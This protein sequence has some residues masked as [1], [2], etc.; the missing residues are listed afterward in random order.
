MLLTVS[1][2]SG[3]AD[4]RR[5][6]VTLS[7][8]IGAS[9]HQADRIGIIATELASN[10]RKHAGHGTLIAQTFDDR[11]GYGFELLAFDEGPGMG[12]VS[13]CL[14]DGYSSTAS[15]GI[16][17]GAVKRFAD[18]FGIC[19]WPE[20]GTAIVARVRL[21]DVADEPSFLVGSMVANYPGEEV[22]GDAFAV[23]QSA[24]SCVGLLAD[25]SGH[26]ELAQEAA[27]RAVQIFS[28]KH[29]ASPDAICTD[30]H[31]NLR[32][33]RG[34]AI[35]VAEIDLG[36]GQVAYSGVGN[37]SAALICQ[38]AV[39]RMV[40]QNGTAGHV[41]SR[42]SVFY[43]PCDQQP[44][45]VLHSDGLSSRWNFDRYPGLAAAHPGLI[46]SILFRD[47]R[48]GR[49]DATVVVMRR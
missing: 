14:T 30:I 12:D 47:F 43:Y 5:R 40:S 49:D 28:R 36:K 27:A 4:S 44:C 32:T 8:T 10:M 38:G 2:V 33:T 35:G 21:R 39:R 48:R 26:G 9:E 3:I 7:R 25:G 41:A 22:C 37:I 42:I 6:A 23:R 18:T 29:A 45:V 16:G 46:A 31:D 11:E 34:A 13:K 19:S 20:K 15:A 17:L 24:S 1:D